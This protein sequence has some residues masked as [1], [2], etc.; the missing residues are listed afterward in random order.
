MTPLTTYYIAIQAFSRWGDG[1]ALSEV[2]KATTNAGPKVQ[3]DKTSLE[4]AVDATKGKV[5][6]GDFTIANNG[7]GLLKYSLAAATVKVSASTYAL[8]AP[9]PGLV[10]PYNGRMGVEKAVN[11]RLVAADFKLM[12]MASGNALDQ[13]YLCLLGRY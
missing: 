10:V 11:H 12:L 1:S 8:S 3:L 5:A 9:K 13:R 6:Q 2:K 4:L 7:E